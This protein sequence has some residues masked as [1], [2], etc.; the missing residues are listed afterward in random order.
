MLGDGTAV[1]L[2][3]GERDGLARLVFEA[4]SLPIAR[5]WLDERSLVAV[6]STAGRELRLAPERVGGL[7]LRVAAWARTH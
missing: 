2:V 4:A 6:D 1:T 7:D 5:V 3:A